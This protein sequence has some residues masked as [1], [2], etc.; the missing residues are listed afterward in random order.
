MPIPPEMIHRGAEI[1]TLFRDIRIFEVFLT[2]WFEV[3]DGI[4]IIRPIYGVWI[5]GIQ[6]EFDAILSQHERVEDLYG[7][8]ELVWR[9]TQHSITVDGTTSTLE[10]GAR[11]TGRHLRWETLGALCSA[12]GLIAIDMSEYD[13]AFNSARAKG[14]AKDKRTMTE[15]IRKAIEEVLAFCRY[16]ETT[17]DVYVCNLYESVLLL[18]SLR[19]DAY[20]GAWHRM[21]E[22]V[23]TVISL[24]YHQEK[25]ADVNTPFYIAE[26]RTRLFDQIY[27]HDKNIS[28]F[29][30]RPPR[31]S[32]R[33]CVTQLPLD[34]SDEELCLQGA[35]LQTAI[36]RLNDGWNSDNRFR[37]STWRRVWAQHARIREDIL[38]IV[39]GTSVEGM[40]TKAEKIRGRIRQT[41]DSMPEFVKADVIEILN[42]MH[43]DVHPLVSQ[44]E[45]ERIPLNTMNLVWIHGGIIHTEFLLERSLVNRLKSSD[46]SALI[47]KARALLTVILAAVS[48]RDQMRDFTIDMIALLVAYGL[49]AAGVIGV[50]MLK[51][52]QTREYTPD[53]LPR[54]K[55][56][57]DLSVFVS[58]LATVS[59][60]EGNYT[61]CDQGRKVLEKILDKIL[62]P[63]PHQPATGIP[64]NDLG[65]DTSLYF[66]T[67]NDAEF[68]QW[69][70]NLEWERGSLFNQ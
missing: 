57:Q 27:G 60:G 50:E 52:E 13:S 47:P 36:S 29:L 7:L 4:T 54:S 32:H 63:Q 10:W 55:V 66:P 41:N 67:G 38:E 2:R 34:L 69:L 26:L 48:K 33:Y 59:P 3:C 56:I 65:N 62:S 19:G 16:C 35:E 68:M 21:G 44:W 28:T 20:S 40:A 15:T 64:H 39:L 11:H 70:D 5:R 14:I 31:L 49:P 6:Q 46:V 9:N 22:V 8:S 25:R 53:I 58:A 61:I 43:S 12:V 45:R 1:L 17:T 23:D 30:G 24:G 37:R 18:E 42:N 51:Q